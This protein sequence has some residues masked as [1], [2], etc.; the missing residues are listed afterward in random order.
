[1]LALPLIC[2]GYTYKHITSDAVEITTF[3]DS[4][5]SRGLPAIEFSPGPYHNFGGAT[6]VGY[7]L[8]LRGAELDINGALLYKEEPESDAVN[9]LQL[10]SPFHIHVGDSTD[11]RRIDHIYVKHQFPFSEYFSENDSLVILTDQGNFTLYMSEDKRAAVRYAPVIKSLNDELATTERD[12]KATWGKVY[13]I[14]AL[15]VFICMA[16]GFAAFLYFRRLKHIQAE[17]I[18]QLLT[19]ISED[20]MSNRQLKI[21]VSDLM[22]NNFNTINRLC[23]EYFEKA[24]TNLLKK[25][26][27]ITVE[28]E[29]AKLKSQE[30]LS[31]LERTLNTY[32]DDIISKITK[33]LPKLSDAEKTLLIYLYSGLSARTIC[34][35]MDIQIKNFYMRRLRLKSKIMASDAPDKEW[36]VSLM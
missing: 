6:I 5:Y 35:L 1:M 14:V 2:R 9:P 30:Q 7:K 31:H 17:Q 12:L 28:Q 29:I 20:E 22:R 23:Y 13:N 33:Q 10:L 11:K 15:I 34:I 16:S 25:S 21:K 27:Y 8:I 4:T 3:R 26:I 18:N 19:L 24:D 36:F 32:C